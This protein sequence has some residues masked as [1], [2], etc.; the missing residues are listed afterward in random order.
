MVGDAFIEVNH[1]DIEITKKDADHIFVADDDNPDDTMTVVLS[2]S[3]SDM[4][5]PPCF[6]YQ[7]VEEAGDAPNEGKW[8]LIAQSEERDIKASDS[9]NTFG[10][11]V[12]SDKKV[13]IN[14]SSGI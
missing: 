13:M 5:V 2:N 12:L 7:Y 14:I 6:K 1:H 11:I 10:A 4:S 3:M 9:S 8:K